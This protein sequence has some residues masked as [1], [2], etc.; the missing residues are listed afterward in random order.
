ML[1]GFSHLSSFPRGYKRASETLGDS[2]CSNRDLAASPT[3]LPALRS[4][5][6]METFAPIVWLVHD[7]P[8]ISLVSVI[9]GCTVPVRL[10]R[11]RS[12]PRLP[13]G[14]KGY[15]I[16][17]NLLDLPP[18]HAWEKFAAWGKQYGPS[19]FPHFRPPHNSRLDANL[20][21]PDL[22]CTQ[23]TSYT[24]TPWARK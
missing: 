14:P 12:R 17:G 22:P 16:V 3:P 13:P 18:T 1:Y 19:Y 5:H 20:Y 10:A 9:L 4:S 11:W 15:P 23:E 21:S 8:Y 7:H 2:L 24:S 6:P